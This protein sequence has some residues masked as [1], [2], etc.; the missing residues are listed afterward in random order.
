MSKHFRRLRTVARMSMQ[1]D[2]GL[3][4]RV[5]ALNTLSFVTGTVVGAFLLK[6]LTNAAVRRQWTTATTLAFALAAHQ[7]VTFLIARLYGR[8]YPVLQELNR[9][10]YDRE[11][12]RL[13]ATIPGIEH[14]ENPEYLNELEQLRQH[15]QTLA[16]MLAVTIQASSLLVQTVV[17]VALL[18]AIDPWLMLVPL[19][20]APALV[21]MRRG[22]TLSFA[23]W[24]AVAEPMRLTNQLFGLLTAPSPAKEVRMLRLSDELIDRHDRDWKLIDRT[25]NRADRKA[26]A[27]STGGWMIFALAFVVMIVVTVERA[28]RGAASIGDVVLTVT[29]ATQLNRQIA[30]VLE[31]VNRLIRNSR[32]IERFLWLQD[33]ASGSSRK[34]L[35]ARD[36]PA[37]LKDGIRLTDVR[38]RY[39]GTDSDVLDSVS[40]HLEAGTV[41]ALLGENGAGK[42]TL[43]KLLTGM[44]QPT[45]GSV[46]ADGIPLFELDVAEWRASATAAFQDFARLELTAQQSVGVGHLPDLEDANHVLSALDRAG[47]DDLPAQLPAG[48]ATRLGSS[49]PGGADLSGGQWQKVALGRAMMRDAPLLLI[50]DEPTA[51]LDPLAERALFERYI[52]WASTAGRRTGTVTL[53]I[54]HRY[55]TTRQADHI[56]LL[57]DG[58][59]REQGSHDELMA[60]HGLY[61]ELYE[62]QAR[63]YR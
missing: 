51:S 60:S 31:V 17:I 15:P 45:S 5:L 24:D 16:Q 57:E 28:A 6:L 12:L 23:A 30:T 49:F 39:P 58:R 56:V 52:E 44:Y 29:L 7:G 55:S 11:I 14:Y 27:V 19:L 2:R 40:L 9:E 53:L 46:T 43:V 36:V 1:A 10:H 62:L 33:Y 50:L 42:T 61:A 4:L 22:Q 63:A 18:G 38:F 21:T 32:A 54:S 20:A 13:T 26:T 25:L 47:A 35:P 34:E 37:R 3:T 59:V 8:T 48:L 41:V